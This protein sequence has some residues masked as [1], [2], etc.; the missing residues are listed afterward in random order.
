M[1]Q[2]LL[3]EDIAKW[4][5]LIGDSIQKSLPPTINPSEDSISNILHALIAGRMQCWIEQEEG[6]VRG[7]VVT[8]V[9][10]DEF[11][12]NINL[13]IYSMFSNRTAKPDDWRDALSTLKIYAK[14]RGCYKIIAFTNKE[15][16]ESI[17]EK[18]GGSVSEVLVQFNLD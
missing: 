18:L 16:V 14:N 12:E 1:L 13:L 6:A 3:S 10:K 7:I 5:N 4:W 17:V 11:S 2:R 15:V 8:A 9:V